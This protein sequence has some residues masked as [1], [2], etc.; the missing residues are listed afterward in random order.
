MVR[1]RKHEVQ[2]DEVRNSWQVVDPTRVHEHVLARC[3]AGCG[4]EP[5]WVLAVEIARGKSKR[6]RDCA[7]RLRRKPKPPPKP[8]RPR[9]PR[10]TLDAKEKVDRW[11]VLRTTRGG[12]TQAPVRCDC[13]YIG[14]RR[15]IEL[16]EGRARKCPWCRGLKMARKVFV[17]DGRDVSFTRFRTLRGRLRI[18]VSHIEILEDS[19]GLREQ[20]AEI[21]R[22]P[23]PEQA[24]QAVRVA[25]RERW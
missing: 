9:P 17:L 18:H 12:K 5:Q 8:R 11:T 1:L 24:E 6:C 4:R 20:I 14:R 13:G 21:I 19:P 16:V 2:R 3:L 15:L 23:G 22:G 10:M 7:N 25:V